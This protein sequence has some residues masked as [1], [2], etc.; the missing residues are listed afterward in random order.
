M[1]SIETI[2]WQWKPIPVCP[3]RVWCELLLCKHNNDNAYFCATHAL[4]SRSILHFL[5]TKDAMFWN[6]LSLFH[7]VSGLGWNLCLEFPVLSSLAGPSS[8]HLTKA[9][10]QVSW[11][12]LWSAVPSMV[13]FSARVSESDYPAGACNND[14]LHGL[15]RRQQAVDSIRISSFL[16]PTIWALHLFKTRCIDLRLH[17]AVSQCVVEN[18]C[19]FRGNEPHN[20]ISGLSNVRVQSSREITHPTTHAWRNTGSER[21]AWLTLTDGCLSGGWTR[22]VIFTRHTRHWD[23]VQEH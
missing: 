4:F 14:R 9:V 23:S 10:G 17:D 12:E 1:S 16:H 3:Y 20:T 6:V 18:F 19:G 8:W 21:C 7:L 15:M 5:K 22:T 13:N 2:G 11:S